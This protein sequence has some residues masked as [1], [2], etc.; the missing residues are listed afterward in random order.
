[1]AYIKLEADNVTRFVEESD[2]RKIEK[3]RRNFFVEP[4]LT[5]DGEIKK[6]SADEV[7]ALLGKKG[8]GKDLN[9]IF[10]ISKTNKVNKTKNTKVD[11]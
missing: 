1:M 4:V 6:Y 2:I 9:S 7:K 8:K 5:E 3:L 11:K 10:N